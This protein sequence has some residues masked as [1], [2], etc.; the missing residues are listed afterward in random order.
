METLGSNDGQKKQTLTPRFDNEDDFKDFVSKMEE[1]ERDFQF[2][3]RIDL[4]GEEE[5]Q[6]LKENL[7]RCGGI[8]RVSIHPTHVGSDWKHI[9]NDEGYPD[10]TNYPP[11]EVLRRTMFKKNSPPTLVLID[12]DC[13]D[14]VRNSIE[15]QGLKLD[16]ESPVYVLPTLHKNGYIKS[17]YYNDPNYSKEDERE[18]IRYGFIGAHNLVLFFSEIGV[19]KILMSGSMLEVDDRALNRCVGSFIDSFSN[20]NKYLI[21]HDQKVNL[22]KIQVGAATVPHGRKELKEHGYEEFL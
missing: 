7:E 9:I 3:A 13:F 17:M 6:H 12:E 18:L 19:K 11:M 16:A 22:I 10:Y 14:G 4:L 2:T 20:V 15:K 21:K 8:L 1:R 5:R